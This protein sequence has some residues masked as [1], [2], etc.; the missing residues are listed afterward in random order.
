[1]KG[2]GHLI[3]FGALGSGDFGEALLEIG[4][5]WLVGGIELFDL[6]LF[7]DFVDDFLG[8]ENEVDIFI[9]FLDRFC[10]F[11]TVGNTVNHLYKFFGDL[12]NSLSFH[13]FDL[14]T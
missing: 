12:S 7:H 9:A 2:F 11:P 5:V 4:V 8:F 14:P 10:L 3:A 13:F 1:L 6:V